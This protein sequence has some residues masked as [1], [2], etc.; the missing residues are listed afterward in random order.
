MAPLVKQDVGRLQISMNDSA[1]V[2]KLH[3]KHKHNTDDGNRLSRVK[4]R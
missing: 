2:D 3:P 1:Q 4:A